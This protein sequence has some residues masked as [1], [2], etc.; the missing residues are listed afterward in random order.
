MSDDGLRGRTAPSASVP[1]LIWPLGSL[2]ASYHNI[3]AYALFVHGSRV[4]YVI[5]AVEINHAGITTGKIIVTPKSWGDHHTLRS[6]RFPSI[7][8]MSI[9]NPIPF[10]QSRASHASKECIHRTVFVVQIGTAIAITTVTV[11]RELINVIAL[12]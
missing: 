8:G 12:S 1:F 5:I 7:R 6:P 9:G 2:G 3:V 4:A 10:I 11:I